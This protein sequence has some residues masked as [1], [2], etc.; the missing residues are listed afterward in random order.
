MS[1][2]PNVILMSRITPDDLPM[3]T[4][5]AIVEE[6]KKRDDDDTDI[7]IG[8]WDYHAVVIE[9]GYD[10]GWQISGKDGDI[11]FF[12]LITYGYGESVS[13]NELEKQKES[14]DKWSK[15]VCEKHHA[16]YEILVS[17]NYW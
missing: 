17:A 6:Y 8:G 11:I 2:H 9:G 15:V 10:E 7:I 4:M 13:W 3:K 1:T 16:S 12:D 14:L 5:K